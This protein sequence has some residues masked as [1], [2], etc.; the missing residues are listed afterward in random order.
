MTPLSGPELLAHLDEIIANRKHGHYAI[1]FDGNLL[2]RLSKDEELCA[3]IGAAAFVMPDGIAPALLSSWAT[4]RKV[5]RVPGPQFMQLACEFGVSRGWRHFFYGS[6]PEVVECVSRKMQERVPGL[7]VVGV[8]APPFRP[9]THDE[10]R[11]ICYRIESVDADIVWVALGGPKQ[12]IWMHQH[13]GRLRVPV[14]LGVGAAFDFIS[15]TQRR[16]PR[17]VQRLGC[18]WLFRMLTGG[19]RLFRR[20]LDAAFRTIC[21]LIKAYCG[22]VV[23]WRQC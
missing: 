7:V 2:S 8:H 9:L 20:N 19:P 16:A 10:D 17:V 23:R 1:F 15:L 4:K 18:E 5:Q 21:I 3:A 22:Q 6:T 14:M 13:Q 11:E 12:E